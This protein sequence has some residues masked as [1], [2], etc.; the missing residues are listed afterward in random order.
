MLWFLDLPQRILLNTLCIS[1]TNYH[2][3]GITIISSYHLLTRYPEMKSYIFSWHFHSNLGLVRRNGTS[4]SCSPNKLHTCYQIV[5]LLCISTYF[6]QSSYQP[7]LTLP[8]IC[9]ETIFS[10]FF[11]VYISNN[12]DKFRKMLPKILNSFLSM[13]INHY[14]SFKRGTTKYWELIPNK[15]HTKLYRLF[16]SYYQTMPHSFYKI[17]IK[18]YGHFQR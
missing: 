8:G 10:T 5:L 9:Y 16:Q 2:L 18:Q 12:T 14:W 17:Y 15:I 7:I 1:L 11:R 6:F 13:H 4:G 3:L